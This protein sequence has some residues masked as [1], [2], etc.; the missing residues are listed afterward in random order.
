MPSLCATLGWPGGWSIDPGD[1]SRGSPAI[2]PHLCPPS[3][4]RGTDC[5]RIASHALGPAHLHVVPWLTSLLSAG[6]EQKFNA[7]Q[8]A[9]TQMAWGLTNAP[10]ADASPFG[11]TRIVRDTF[12][13]KNSNQCAQ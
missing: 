9:Y 11:R 10:K 3:L 1:L 13:N 2:V 4:V 12:W 5:G 8:T 6:P 7:A